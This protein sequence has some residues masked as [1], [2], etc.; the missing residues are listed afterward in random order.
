MKFAVPA[1]PVAVPVIAP[2]EVLSDSPGGSEP[3]VIDHVYGEVPPDAA[4]V[5]LYANPTWPAGSE[6]VVTCSVD[7]PVV[8]DSGCVVCCVGVELSI[9][10]TVKLEVPGEPV[11]VP[12]ISPVEVLR[13]NPAGSDP[14]LSDHEYGV[15]PPEAPSVWS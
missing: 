11:G 9:T 4:S 8:I 10:S 14:E 12:E 6:L 7:G 3:E 2:V 15:V 13:V 5:W 1:G